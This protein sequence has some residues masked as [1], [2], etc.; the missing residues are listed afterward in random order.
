MVRTLEG[1]K[2]F[3]SCQL[4]TA[5]PRHQYFPSL[6]ALQTARIKAPDVVAMVRFIEARGA[7]D[8]AKRAM[9]TTGQIFRYAIAHG[10][11]KR[12]PAAGFHPSGV[13]R[14]ARTVNYARIEAKELPHLLRQIEAYSDALHR[15]GVKL[16]LFGISLSQS[17][18]ALFARP[19]TSPGQTP[20]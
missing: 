6:G 20:C 1:W 12:N 13:L 3:S 9:G 16:S 7:H 14:A 8:M 19:A 11:A 15:Q 4:D 18:A 10:Y 5:T 17:A 2:E